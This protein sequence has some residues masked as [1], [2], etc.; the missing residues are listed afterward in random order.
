[1]SYIG[2]D[3]SHLGTLI[4]PSLPFCFK[5]GRVSPPSPRS[6]LSDSLPQL[7]E[8]IDI[9]HD[10]INK[11]DGRKKFM[12]PYQYI[13]HPLSTDIPAN[14][15]ASS[16][17]FDPETA[18]F[19]RHERFEGDKSPVLHVVQD[20]ASLAESLQL[21]ALDNGGGSSIPFPVEKVTPPPPPRIGPF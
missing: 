20:E 16:S 6:T 9:L 3:N 18:R 13:F 7:Q 1:M 12:A 10:D 17:G 8:R 14:G 2:F 15:G 21:L 11:T 5:W 19:V 4:H